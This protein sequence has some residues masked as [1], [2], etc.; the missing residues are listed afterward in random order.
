MAW[1]MLTVLALWRALTFCVCWRRLRES[2]DA[3]LRAVVDGRR[4]T[5]RALLLTCLRKHAFHR[6]ARLLMTDKKP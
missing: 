5:M 1:A 3:V 4:V 6:F 2:L